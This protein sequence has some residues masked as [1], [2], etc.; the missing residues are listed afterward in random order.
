MKRI[1]LLAG[2]CLASLCLSAQSFY[3]KPYAGYGTGVSGSLFNITSSD[4]YES[5][6]SNNTS[7]S[8]ESVKISFGKGKRFGFAIGTEIT[9]NIAFE[10]AADFS[11]GKSREIELHSNNVY[12]YDQDFSLEI[13]DKY[14]FE[15]KSAQIA[16][17]IIIKSSNR[18]ITQYFKI[19]A[20]INF[21]RFTENFERYIFNTLPTYYPF[22]SYTHVLKYNWTPSAGLKTAIGFEY[23]LFNNLYVF[24]EAQ[25]NNLSASPKK[26]E[27]TEYKY[28]GED[29]LETLTIRERNFEY[30]TEFDDTD[31]A[32]PDKPEKKLPEQFILSNMTIIAGVRFDVNLKKAFK[33]E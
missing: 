9:K 15:S 16:P 18:K 17:G 10:L 25:Y 32:N 11:K 21:T 19:A 23:Y 4:Y 2:I 6:D 12:Q 20:I 26:S 33:A 7:Y 13:N 31:N 30:V 1:L 27:L 3:I 14:Y 5:P 29:R 24:A 22:E 8:Y 28:R